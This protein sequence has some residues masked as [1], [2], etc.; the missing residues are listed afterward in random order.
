M[1]VRSAEIGQFV[2]RGPIGEAHDGEIR[3]MH[4]QQQPRAFADGAFVIRYGSAVRRAHFAQESAA[5]GHDVRDTK[6]LSD[7]NQFAARDDHFPASRQGGQREED[8]GRIV[9]HHAGCLRSGEA[10]KQRARVNVAPSSRAGGD[11]VFEI[12]ILTGGLTDVFDGG[13]GKRCATQIRVQNHAG[14][15]DYRPQRRREQ[16][17]NICGDRH[18]EGIA[19]HSLRRD[20]E[21]DLFAQPL[22]H[23]SCRID[24]EF[25]AHA[26][27]QTAQRGQGQQFIHRRNVAEQFGA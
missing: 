2:E 14:R 15:V 22:Q 4:A 23:A 18:G 24:D 20:A 5:L 6:R 27:S 10:G 21:P 1:R 16:Q 8:S 17:G 25:A 26:M 11:V 3:A 13:F 9:V 12:C 7:L 19:L